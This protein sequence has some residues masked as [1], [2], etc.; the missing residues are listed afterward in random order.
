MK[1]I[2]L[3]EL[4]ETYSR[5]G[6]VVVVFPSRP[7]WFSATEGIES[8]LQCFELEDPEKILQA[9]TDRLEVPL[10]DATMMF[11]QIRDML[12]ASGVLLIDG[13]LSENV[14]TY[15]PDFQVNNVENVLVIAT[16]QNCNMQ[17][18]MCYASA[19][20]PLKNEMS[21]E[22]IM[23]IV[24]QLSE[25]GWE[26]TISR[27]ALTGGEIFSRPDAVS[28]ME[29]VHGKGFGVQ[30]NSNATLIT[31]DD[32]KRMALLPNLR[33]SV[34]L[35]GSTP[36][37]HDLIR[38][39]GAYDLTTRTITQMTQVGIPVAVNMFVHGEN[40]TDIGPT[41]SLAD[42]FGVY[43]FNCLNMMHVGRANTAKGK[44]SLRAVRLDTFYRTLFETIRNDLRFQELMIGSTFANQIMGIMAGV[45]SHSCGLGT[46]R[47]VYVKADGSLYPCADT[48]LPD[49]RLGNLRENSL[50]DIWENSPILMQARLL[51]VDTMNPQCAACPLRYMCGG[52]CRGENYQTTRDLTGPHFKCEEIF[53]SILE[54]MYILTEEPNLFKIKTDNLYSVISTHATGA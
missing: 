16:T 18:G 40:L 47:A 15:T 37:I 23:S 12:Y 51:N 41:L 29:Y 30:V 19:R 7:Y 54:L 6:V 21:T 9:I 25:M 27:V 43:A 8:I 5:D 10:E 52:N 46:N 2:A 1:R 50:K 11:E 13:E 26:N 44:A 28:L 38:G 4:P 22:E 34:S 3:T 14:T 35:D 20:R 39:K 31:K 53:S 32:I 45:K 24:D 17:C 42:S 33:M 36:E 48:A 49:F